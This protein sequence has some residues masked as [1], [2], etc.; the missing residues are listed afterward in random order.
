M[1]S[2]P[3]IRK[4]QSQD[5]DAFLEHLMRLDAVSLRLRFGLKVSDDTL[6][7][8]A[9]NIDY[10]QN[11][12]HGYFVNGI[13]CAT[14]ELYIFSHNS[15]AIAEAAFSVESGYQNQGI[16]TKLMGKVIDTAQERHIEKLYMSCLAEN[17]RMKR[18]ASKYNAVLDFEEGEFIA[19]IK[20]SE[21]GYI[22]PVGISSLPSVYAQ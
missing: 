6:A 11:V 13:L 16:G 14:A 20:P 8:Y 9:H 10:S 1:L 12:V 17:S 2:L 3:Q 21:A 15:E 5:K 4:L 19:K 7:T 18:I 22:P